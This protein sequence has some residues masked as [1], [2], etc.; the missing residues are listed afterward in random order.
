M[1]SLLLL[2]FLVGMRHALEADHLAAVASL[3]SAAGGSLRGALRHGAAWGIG[4]SLTLFLFA[5]LVIL[6][7]AAMPAALVN[8]LELAVG[9]MLLALGADVIARLL[10]ER[11]HFHTHRHA[12]GVQHFHAHSHHGQ[13]RHAFAEHQHRHLRGFPWRALLVGLMHGMA[14]SAALILLT[15]D[16]VR[17]PWT[18][19]AYIALFG[20]GS[21]LGMAL[22]S[23]AI[24]VPLRRSARG[25]TW[26]HNGVHAGIGVLTLVLGALLVVERGRVLLAG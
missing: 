24:A 16:S 2:G 10:R 13:R 3:N 18:G 14:G 21:T 6:L 19:L 26:L 17:T 25:L 5:S 7:N 12:G 11:V 8:A 15:L 23:T 1:I 20:L 22:L 9:A 4:H